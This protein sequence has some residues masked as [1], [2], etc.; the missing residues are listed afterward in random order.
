VNRASPVEASQVLAAYL[1]SVRDG[2]RYLAFRIL[3]EARA[4]GMDLDRLYLD[5]L[6]PALREIGELWQ[7][8]E[9]SVAEEHLATG[10][11]QAAMARLFSD[12]FQWSPRGGRTLIAACAD[13]ERH[14]VGLRMIC[15]LL[16]LRG[17]ETIYLGATVPIDSLVTMIARRKPDAV[18]L[19]AALAPHVP[20]LGLMIEQIRTLIPDPPLILVGGRPFLEDPDL[21]GRVGADLTAPDAVRTV[22]LLQARMPPR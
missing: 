6:Q 9:L 2:D 22:E 17:W 5:V 13:L 19:S 18:A 21:A 12:A 14:E 3:A 8:N 4:G 15:D 20:R 11:T 16:E 7:R 10:I 1:A